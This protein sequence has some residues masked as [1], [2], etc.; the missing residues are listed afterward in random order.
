MRQNLF[1]FCF[2]GFELSVALVLVLVGQRRLIELV[3]LE[4]LLQLVQVA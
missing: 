3:Q 2:S 1:R 4:R